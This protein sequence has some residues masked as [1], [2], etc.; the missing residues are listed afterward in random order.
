[1][2]PALQV[3]SLPLSHQGSPITIILVLKNILEFL[4]VSLLGCGHGW[5]KSDLWDTRHHSW[6]MNAFLTFIV[7]LH[8]LR[9]S[10][11]P[12]PSDLRCVGDFPV[13]LHM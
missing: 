9:P 8:P 10:G 2:A 7:S 3:D 13:S 11:G 6:E 4:L 12:E 1:M 5:G